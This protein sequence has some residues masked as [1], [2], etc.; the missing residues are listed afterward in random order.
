MLTVGSV[1]TL[2]FLIS[3]DDDLAMK[4]VAVN[5]VLTAGPIGIATFALIMQ[6]LSLRVGRV[7]W[8]TLVH[9][10][11]ACT[12]CRSSRC[13]LTAWCRHQND[14]CGPQHHA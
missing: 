14:A 2:T 5:L 7:R 6:K 12:P 9:T 10:L 1:A 8:P 4:P 13:G 11:A 3:S